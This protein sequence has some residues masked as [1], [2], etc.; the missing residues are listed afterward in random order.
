[1]ASVFEGLTLQG[2]AAVVVEALVRGF[3]QISLPG[4]QPAGTAETYQN[5]N[6][7]PASS[8]SQASASS[9]LA[10][11]VIGGSASRSRRP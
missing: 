8:A 6:P 11:G 9:R 10:R 2:P 5:G 7:T 1:M 3:G 4:R